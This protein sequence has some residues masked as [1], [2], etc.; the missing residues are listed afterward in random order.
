MISF[1]SKSE[2]VFVE[3]AIANFNLFLC[4]INP[5]SNNALPLDIPYKF[6]PCIATG[7]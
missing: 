6:N 3:V 2:G 4:C 1:V 7:L 5:T